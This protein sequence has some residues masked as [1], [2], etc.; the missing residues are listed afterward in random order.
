MQCHDQE[1]IQTLMLTLRIIMEYT[2]PIA[3]DGSFSVI[4]NKFSANPIR[5]TY[6]IPLHSLV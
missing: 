5:A 6:A 3:K 4:E 1:L 2:F